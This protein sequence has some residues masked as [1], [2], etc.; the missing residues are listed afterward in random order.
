MHKTKQKEGKTTLCVFLD[1]AYTAHNKQFH[2]QLQSSRISITV[3]HSVE[4]K[5]IAED[6]KK[7]LGKLDKKEYKDQIKASK[8]ISEKIDELLAIYLGKIDERQGI[9]RN[10]D[11]NVSQRIGN[12]GFYV[13]SRQNGITSTERELIKHAEDALNDALGKTNAFFAE[14]W[15]QYRS[16]MESLDISPFKETKTFNND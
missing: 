11:P 16:E 4:S 12:A 15:Q 6:Y 9:T 2:N 7:M 5:N 8:D 10:P 14:D 1:D 3:F 13:G